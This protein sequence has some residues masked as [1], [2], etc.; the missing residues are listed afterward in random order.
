M[1]ISVPDQI[2]TLLHKALA[3]GSRSN[4][5]NP[6][7]WFIGICASASI[8]SFRL[9]IPGWLGLMFGIFAG[10]GG[11]FY[12]GFYAYFV[13]I[14]KEDCLRSEKYTLQKMAIQR[15]YVG[16]DL[17]GFFKLPEKPLKLPT[18]PEQKEDE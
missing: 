7:A 10:L 12:L 13:F 5:L 1:I 11:L 6:L 17:T 14:G 3:R 2:G 9:I 8:T 16:D 18:K 15:G 4:V